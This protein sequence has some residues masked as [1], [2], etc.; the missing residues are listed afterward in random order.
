V[1]RTAMPQLGEHTKWCA[2][3]AGAN[4]DGVGAA[5]LISLTGLP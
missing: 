3:T 2:L 1:Q 5:S 4:V